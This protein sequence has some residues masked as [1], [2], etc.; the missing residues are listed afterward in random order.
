MLCERCNKNNVCML[1][2]ST[3]ERLCR[4]CFIEG[5]EEDVHLT[6]LKK[7]MFE[8]KDKICIAVSGGKD[9]SVLAH[10][11]VHIKKK[12]NYKWDLFLLAIDEGIKGYRD[13][14]L[15]VVYKLGKLYNLPLKVLKFED[16]FS[17]T[18]DNVVKFIGRKNNCTVCGVFRR[19]A[20][21]KGAILFN[22]TKLVTGHNA[23]D[24]AETILMNMCRGDIDKL[25]KNI[26]QLGEN[27]FFPSSVYNSNDKY[28]HVSDTYEFEKSNA[29]EKEY[30]QCHV[31][32]SINKIPLN[33]T[34]HNGDTCACDS[35]TS[36]ERERNNHIPIFA[37]NGHTAKQYHVDDQGVKKNEFFLPRLK[38][39]MLCYEKEI[40]LYAFHLKLDYFSTECTY[41]P[42]SFRGNLRSFIKEIENINPQFILNI[43]Y[44]ADFF[45]INTDNKKVL[46]VCTKCGAY[47]SNA[48]CKACLIV[49]GLNNYTDNSFLYSN[50]RKTG[51]KKISVR[52]EDG[53]R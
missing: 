52:Y 36:Y 25:A 41:S 46:Q 20:M 12:Y 19:Q 23:D 37:K 14:S 6:I 27:F 49:D 29:N 17:Y 4:D 22:A 10:V 33:G 44:S 39:L 38:P 51:K 35:I 53:G 2:P 1:K 28:T 43:I 45:Y 8:E 24:S 30:M 16:I 7:H 18:M 15:K 47:T 48:V 42:N 13:D 11:L 50:K 5:F 40:V 31:P 34:K 3:R 32:V 21:E 9:S 26:N